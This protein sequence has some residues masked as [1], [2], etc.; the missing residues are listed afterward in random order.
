MHLVDQP[1]ALA[2]AVERSAREAAAYFGRPEVYLER[3]VTRAHHVEAQILAD[4]RGHVSFLGERDCSMQRRYQKL[5]EESP[6]PMVDAALRARI[7]EAATGIAREAGYVNA[8]TV[9]F[10]L[11]PDGHFYFMEVN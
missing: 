2:E 3:Y 6:S 7:G 8:G 11:E 1:E 4:G 9:E 10:L 5:V